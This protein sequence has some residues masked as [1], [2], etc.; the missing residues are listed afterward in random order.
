MKFIG[1][2]PGPACCNREGEGRVCGLGKDALSLIE[3]SLLRLLIHPI[4]RC[5]H[6]KTPTPKFMSAS[7]STPAN[8]CRANSKTFFGGFS[9]HLPL[10]S[11]PPLASFLLRH[12]KALTSFLRDGSLQLDPRKS[13]RPVKKNR[14]RSAVQ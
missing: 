14:T 10:P 8:T 3:F 1:P 6:S 7:A 12:Y 9:Q 5:F 11:P 4:I 2:G 13:F